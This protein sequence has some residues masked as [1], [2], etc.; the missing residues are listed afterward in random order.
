MNDR[1]DPTPDLSA[2]YEAD[3]RFLFG[4][5]YRM[6]GSAAAVVGVESTEVMR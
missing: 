1:R 5:C 4:L 3:R 6:T 2:A